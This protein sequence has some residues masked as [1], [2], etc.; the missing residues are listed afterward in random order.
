LFIIFIAIF[1]ET[2]WRGDSVW[3]QLC[4][5]EILPEKIVPILGKKSV[6]AR[7]GKI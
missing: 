4:P 7:S 2:Y 6:P 3:E 1:I 5:G